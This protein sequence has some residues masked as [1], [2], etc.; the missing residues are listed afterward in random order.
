MSRASSGIK[1]YS[2]GNE[3][4][5]QNNLIIIQKD[6][7]GNENLQKNLIIIENQHFKAQSNIEH[8]INKEK[9]NKRVKEIE[10]NVLNLNTNTSTKNN[11]I[12]IEN[13]ENIKLKTINQSETSDK[14]F[15]QSDKALISSE[16]INENDEKRT[17]IISTLKIEKN[18]IDNSKNNNEEDNE[19]KYYDNDDDEDEEE[20][21]YIIFN[22][23]ERE[24]QD[25]IIYQSCYICER[26]YPSYKLYSASCKKHFICRKCFKN[27]YEE[28]IEEGERNFKCP[29]YSCNGY[30]EVNKEL[31]NTIISPTYINLIIKNET[32][33][34]Y[35]NELN[36]DAATLK[37]QQ[38]Y[39]LNTK[40]SE[41][42]KLYTHKHVID[43]NSNKNFFMYNKL[44]IQ[45]CP[46]CNTQSLFSKTGTHFI[47]CLNCLNKICKY[48]FKH[49]TDLHMDISNESHCKIYY[50]QKAIVEKKNNYC[51]L[52]FLE[53]FMLFASFYLLI[54][55]GFLY[56]K[57]IVKCVLCLKKEKEICC[58]LNII[59]FFFTFIFFLIL[60]PILLIGFPYFPIFISIFGF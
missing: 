3:Q 36:S 8:E 25:D 49:F 52:I 38:K 40:S 11:L 35:S 31:L 24:N 42:L 16:T 20:K 55:S 14:K 59:I 56:I 28:R 41:K 13:N 5:S 7:K 39:K 19:M 18:K 43:I 23:L 17:K 37:L 53:I 21:N 57:R 46:F 15:Q 47:K 9:I 22:A 50:R 10:K 44:K 26:A 51:L 27:Y 48:C 32:S 34:N 54:S 33:S 12:K 6:R 60:F 58:L 1:K 4:K 45:Y 29:I 2:N 30:W